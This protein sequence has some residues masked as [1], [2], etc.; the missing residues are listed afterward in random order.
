MSAQMHLT[1]YSG[2][3]RDMGAHEAVY[4]SLF[5]AGGIAPDAARLGAAL[6][7]IEHEAAWLADRALRSGDEAARDDYM[8][9]GERLAAD[10]RSSM[11]WRLSTVARGEIAGRLAAGAYAARWKFKS[12]RWRWLGY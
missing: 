10:R 2:L 12:R 3:I 6:R 11:L 5:G 7:S 9:V 4:R 1:T 8:R